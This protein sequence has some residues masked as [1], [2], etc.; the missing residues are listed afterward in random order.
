MSELET[1]RT[2][3]ERAGRRHR[4]AKALR[5]LWYGLLIAAIISLLVL[6]AFHLFPLP[7]GSVVIA[8]LLP[9]PGMMVGFVIGGRRKPDMGEV[10]RWVDGQQHLKE[11]LSTALEVSSESNGTQWGELVISDA[12]AHAKGVDARQLLPFHLPKACR[13]ALVI[14]VLGAGLGFVPE[15]R[16]KSALQKRA[17]QQNIKET[18]RLL[19]ELTRHNLEKR[20]P[21]FEPTQKSME[22][23]STLGDQLTKQTLTRSDALKDLA[24]VAEKLKDQLKEMGKDPGLKRL[25]EAARNAGGSDSQTAAGLQKQIDSLQKQLGTPTGNPDSLDKFQKSL[26]KL[27]QAAKGMADKNSTG[28]DAERQKLSDSLSALSK[29]MQAMGLQL[30]QLDDAINALVANQTDLFLK[31]L[32]AATTDLEKMREMAKS[33]EQLQQQMEKLG[34]DLAE[35]LKNGQPEIAQQTLQKMITQLNSANLKQEQLQKIL[36]DVSKAV[37]PAGNYGKVAEHLK[38]A[39]SQMKAN[40]KSGAA[41]SLAAAAKELDNLMQQMGDAQELSATLDAMNQASM[42]IGSGQCWRMC[43]GPPSFKPGGKPGGGVGT[44]ADE[45]AEWNGESTAGWDNSSVVRPDM[46]GRGQTDRGKGELNDALK[47]TKVKGQF[48]PGGPMPSITLK[49]VSI[50]GQSKVDYEQAATAAQS[51]AQSALSQEKVPRAYQGAV[52]DYFDDLKK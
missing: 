52:K 19:A 20:P 26:E 29:Q 15:Y 39:T 50:K 3:L 27:Q 41:Q 8:A 12:A 37:D 17:D 1:I 42:C 51:D 36:D 11:R 46:E 25:E 13:W 40:D 43:K 24:N 45:N 23:V 33:L 38:A 4:L 32:E 2:V 49:G 14:L 35:Q 10:A 6:G 34:K 31:D 21:A 28:S 30:P 5:G 48:T 7:L 9:I 44:W 18:G 47:P 16:S 22:A